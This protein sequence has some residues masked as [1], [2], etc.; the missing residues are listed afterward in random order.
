[1]K[2]VIYIL[3][4]AL[5]VILS[6]TACDREKMDNDTVELGEGSVNLASL[7]GLSVEVSSS[8]PIT[9]ASEVNTDNY[10]IRIY[11]AEQNL[12]REW[13]YSE[14]PEI[15][16]LR[17][18]SYTV[19][20]L[21]HE[22]QPAEFEVPFY[23]AEESFTIEA[24]KVKDL[25]PL[26]CKLNNIKVSVTYDDKLKEVM[27]EDVKTTVTVGDASLAFA[28]DE[29][30]N[31]YFK[32]N[33][34]GNNIMKAVMTG[35]IDGVA[36]EVPYPIKNVKP[37]QHRLIK[38]YLKY[39]NDDGYI[40][41]G[42]TKL[43]LVIVATCTVIEKGFTNR[44]EEE[45]IIDPNPP[46]PSGKAPTIV[47]DGFDIDESLDVP[48]KR[49][50]GGNLV[51]I[52]VVVN[53]EAENG[54]SNLKVKIDSE[55]LTPELLEEVGLASEFD[56]AYPGDLR[57]GL[58]SLGFPVGDQVLGKTTLKFDI[59]KFTPLLGSYGPATHKFIITAIDQSG[60]SVEK[61]LTLISVAEGE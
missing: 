51:G 56:L 46:T 5:A 10:L 17:V 6:F 32:S 11:D 54:F 37:G 16:T 60:N 41:G 12:V 35:T 36:R 23:Y 58:E 8:T 59:T 50:E 31:G 3:F 49:D 33:V 9:R 15:F 4:F 13:K 43:K 14:L 24:N 18:G 30:R 52:T 20:A 34:D 44:E 48:I 21:S 61:T 27:G 28:Y 55:T 39:V 57:T 53:I 29:T 42:F 26:V 45:T 40:E 1:M 47:G 2:K 19:Q 22:V 38:F 7:K 25:E